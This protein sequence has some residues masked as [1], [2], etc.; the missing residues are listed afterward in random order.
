MNQYSLRRLVN[1]YNQMITLL[2]EA[3]TII[4]SDCH[5]LEF[6]QAKAYWMKSIGGALGGT[7][8]DD[9]MFT[10]KKLLKD[11]GYDPDAVEELDED[12]EITGEFYFRK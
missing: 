1:I 11:N 4:K 9:Q 7:D 2:L 10:F 3:K 5:S 6:N 8:W 12:D